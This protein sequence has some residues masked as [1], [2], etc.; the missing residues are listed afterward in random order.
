M[1]WTVITFPVSLSVLILNTNMSALAML[2]VL[3]ATPNQSQST[4]LNIKVMDPLTEYDQYMMKSFS[5]MFC[6]ALS[7]FRSF[8]SF[9]TH[10]PLR[11]D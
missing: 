3:K 10:V 1:S 2:D 8:F 9:G 11:S 4:I 6:T 7:S 5:M